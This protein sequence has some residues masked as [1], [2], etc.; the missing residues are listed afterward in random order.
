MRIICIALN[1][2]DNQTDLWKK[3]KVEERTVS[4]KGEG[5]PNSNVLRHQRVLRPE[6][7]QCKKSQKSLTSVCRKW[8]ARTTYAKLSTG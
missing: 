8:M 5:K 6:S 3:V 1:V 7:V 4:K 2:L